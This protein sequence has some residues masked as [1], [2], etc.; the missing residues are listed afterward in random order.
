MSVSAVCYVSTQASGLFFSGRGREKEGKLFH[1]LF[2]CVFCRIAVNKYGKMEN[3]HVH[4][5]CK[6]GK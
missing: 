1:D 3:N 6:K 2:F 4:G 5:Y